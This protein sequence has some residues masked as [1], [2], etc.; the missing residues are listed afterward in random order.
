[1]ALN[2]ELSPDLQTA[3]LNSKADA[4]VTLVAH[5]GRRFAVTH[6]RFQPWGWQVVVA[7]ERKAFAALMQDIRG[8]YLHL[9]IVLGLAVV[10]FLF[11]MEE[12]VRRPIRA[13]IG[14]V[15]TGGNAMPTGIAEYDFLT[16]QLQTAIK[17]KHSL[18]E[19]LEKTHFIYSHDVTGN[20]TYLSPS[21]T[22]ILGYQPEEFMTHF[23]TYLTDHP[24]NR[25]VARYTTLSI[26][27]QTQPPYEVEVFHKDG[28]RHWL[29]GAEVPV[30]NSAGTVT[31]VEGI[32][33]DIT[34]KK[35]IEQEREQMI[36]ELQK[37]MTEI[38]TLRGIIPICASCKKVRDDE[39]AWQQVEAYIRAH[40]EAQFSH[41][42]CP[43]CLE[44]EYPGFSQRQKKE[45]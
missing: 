27:G 14:S 38:R 42:I 8:L 10:A 35:K 6:V 40:S 44:K 11:V 1:M 36:A 16:E 26:Q 21:I 4:R 23:S 37:A 15:R 31:A 5:D 13:I 22:G 30:F 19:S 17:R 41:G 29:E 18:V 25:D 7:R 32:A 43:D 33:R 20:F 28:S 3:L 34:D 12:V 45:R 39:G 24:V 2:A 9:A